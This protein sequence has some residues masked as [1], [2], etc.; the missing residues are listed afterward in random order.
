MA[1]TSRERGR[2][3][4]FVVSDDGPVMRSIAMGL[5][6][7]GLAACAHAAPAT[8]IEAP[9]PAPALPKVDA[10]RTIS[11][12]EL[13]AEGVSAE[14]IE[15]EMPDDA[16]VLTFARDIPKGHE[17]WTLIAASSRR[18]LRVRLE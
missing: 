10:P 4:A 17:T 15:L 11:L 6:C 2:R 12:G 13:G 16:R 7:T 3:H 9:A 8:S 18:V 5:V 1:A 14:W